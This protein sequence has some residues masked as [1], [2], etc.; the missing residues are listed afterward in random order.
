ML[1]EG[2]LGDADEALTAEACEREKAIERV[3]DLA[4]VDRS[5][6][7]GDGNPYSTELLRARLRPERGVGQDMEN[8]IE[9][10]TSGN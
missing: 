7:V 1:Q 5:S 4:V 6:K 10:A 2:G 8:R 9:D 3:L